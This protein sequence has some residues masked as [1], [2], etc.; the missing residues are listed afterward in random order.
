M[1]SDPHMRVAFIIQAPVRVRHADGCEV[2]FPADEDVDVNTV[3]DTHRAL[4]AR[5]PSEE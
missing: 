1:T 5:L 3:F 4:H 2:S